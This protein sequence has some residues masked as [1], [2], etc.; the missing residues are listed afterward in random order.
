MSD[1]AELMTDRKAF[2]WKGNLKSVRAGFRGFFA[3]VCQETSA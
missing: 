1:F 2:L 3:P